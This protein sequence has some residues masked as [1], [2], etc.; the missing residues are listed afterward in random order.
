VAGKGWSGKTMEGSEG[1]QYWGVVELVYW[2][3]RQNFMRIDNGPRMFTRCGYLRRDP[4]INLVKTSNFSLIFFFQGI[5]ERFYYTYYYTSTAAN[6]PYH[7]QTPPRPSTTKKFP[8]SVFAHC[9]AS[10]L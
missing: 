1:L 2:S 8:G 6:P 7:N 9:I 3:Q 10:S 4:K 5:K